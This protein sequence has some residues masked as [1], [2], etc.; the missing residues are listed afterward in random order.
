MSLF[1]SLDTAAAGLY[2]QT[3]STSTV[4]NNIANIST[5]GYK[6]SD[7]AFFDLVTTG[8]NSSLYTPGIV[9]TT[10]LLRADAQGQIQQTASATDAAITGNGFFTVKQDT[11][12]SQ[13]FMYT[14]AGSFTIERNFRARKSLPLRPIRSCRKK[15]GLPSSSQIAAA[16]RTQSGRLNSSPKPETKRSKK[17]LKTGSRMSSP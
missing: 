9:T 4:A 5:S 15:I 11:D 3:Q 14:R 7:T 1:G 17:R 10:R 13:Q 12:P 6:K 2:A 16:I 8:I